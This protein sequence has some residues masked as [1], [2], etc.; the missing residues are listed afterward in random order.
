MRVWKLLCGGMLVSD[1]LWHVSAVQAQGG[2]GRFTEI[3][4]WGPVDWMVVASAV[5][6]MVVR[7][8]VVLGVGVSGGD[9]NVEEG[10][11]E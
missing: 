3:G 2:W 6:P 1:V 10:K 7:L 5:W 8:G 9:E 4:E 11:K